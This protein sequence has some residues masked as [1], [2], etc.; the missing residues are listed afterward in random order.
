M[1]IHSN[2]NLATSHPSAEIFSKEEGKL[3]SNPHP[4]IPMEPYGAILSHFDDKKFNL[5]QTTNRY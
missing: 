4:K 1:L 5:Q 2:E 3:T